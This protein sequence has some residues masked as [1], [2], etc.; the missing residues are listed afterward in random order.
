MSYAANFKNAGTVVTSP[1]KSR[2]IAK[3]QNAKLWPHL[4]IAERVTH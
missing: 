2:P 4:P 3:F 1:D